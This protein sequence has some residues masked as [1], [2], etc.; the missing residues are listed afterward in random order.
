MTAVEEL[1]FQK[2]EQIRILEEEI[3]IL[4]SSSSAQLDIKLV[5]YKDELGTYL[6]NALRYGGCETLGN[7]LC[8]TE[9]EVRNIRNIGPTNFERLQ[10]WMN[11]RGLHF[12]LV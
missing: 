6:Y 10:K 2:E 11:E 1:I 12:L 4:K 9:R 8:K 7:L 3:K 5:T